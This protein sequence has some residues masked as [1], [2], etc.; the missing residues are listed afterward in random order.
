MRQAT[1]RTLPVR[2]EIG[3]DR[4]A[5][6]VEDWQGRRVKIRNAMH[7]DVGAAFTAFA[8]ILSEGVDSTGAAEPMRDGVVAECV[9]PQVIAQASTCKVSCGMAHNRAPLREQI[10]QLHRT[11]SVSSASNSKAT[12]PQ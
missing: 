11:A 1:K 2:L 7:V 12:L 3:S 8:D 4:A 5:I 6:E 9:D 10:E